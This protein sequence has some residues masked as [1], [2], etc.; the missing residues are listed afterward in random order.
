MEETI[1]S[2]AIVSAIVGL[3]AII[4]AISLALCRRAFW[5]MIDRVNRL[6]QSNHG[7]QVANRVEREQNGHN[8]AEV[9]R[10]VQRIEDRLESKDPTP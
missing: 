3:P 6:E 9:R 4:S 8:F 7:V 1:L 5:H 2:A 10:L